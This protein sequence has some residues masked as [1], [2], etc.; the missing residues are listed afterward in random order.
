MSEI[1]AADLSQSRTTPR[2]DN[3]LLNARLI[4]GLSARSS[5][6]WCPH[7]FTAMIQSLT[8]HKLSSDPLEQRILRLNRTCSAKPERKLR[9]L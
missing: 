5:Q 2:T 4:E 9:V 7:L 1:E 6:K 3:P 8:L